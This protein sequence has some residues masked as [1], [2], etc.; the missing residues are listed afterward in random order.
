MR[1][2]ISMQLLKDKNTIITGGTAGIGEEIAL[3]FG[4]Q[5]A[6]VAIFGRNEERAKGVIAQLNKHM[7]HSDQ[8]FIYII[9]D[10][11]NTEDSQEA[12]SQVLKEFGSVDVLVNN[13]GITK[14]GLLMKMSESDWDQVLS[15]NL[16]SAY[17]TC[18]SVVRAMMK[19]KSGSIINVSSVS[20]LT[21]N[22]G[23]VNYAASKSGL[24]GFSKSL[25]KEL[26]ARNIRV[27]CIAPG[28]IDTRMTDVLPKSIKEAILGQ[29]PMKKMGTTLDIAKAAVFL[30][31]SMSDYITGQTLT[32]DGGMV[33]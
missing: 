27:N 18:K 29:I 9:L 4:R 17:N 23:Q 13:A 11:A 14:D 19:A 15:V 28:Y 16:K 25:A 21:G 3:E 31:S 30:A 32:V 22:A 20:G 33:M 7:V 10:I 26:A 2:V 12:I 6:N 5:G 1:W 8:K 24:I